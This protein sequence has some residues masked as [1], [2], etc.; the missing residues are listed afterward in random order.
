MQILRDDLRSLILEEMNRNPALV[1]DE[2]GG[3]VMSGS[4]SRSRRPSSGISINSLEW[5][6]MGLAAVADFFP[7]PG[8]AVSVAI[9]IG[10]MSSALLKKN[11]LGA[12]LALASTVPVVGD[13]L[14][15]TGRAFAGGAKLSQPVLQKLAQGLAKVTDIK[16]KQFIIANAS[17]LGVEDA[18]A[19]ATATS[20]ALGDFKRSVGEALA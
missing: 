8:T 7:G 10:L 9:A 5:G 14:Q 4:G 19:V 3:S 18:E 20:R 2:N 13:A 12:A 16:I 15:I 17:K 6:A 1:L 11:Y